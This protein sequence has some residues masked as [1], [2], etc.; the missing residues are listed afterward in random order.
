[1]AR[2]WTQMAKTLPNGPPN[3][4]ADV[5]NALNANP[6]VQFL[7]Q[8]IKAANNDGVFALLCLG[9]DYPS[10]I[11]GTPY[12]EPVTGKAATKRLPISYIDQNQPWDWWAMA[13][14]N[15]YRFQ[16][17]NGTLVGYVNSSQST[18]APFGNPAGAW[19]WGF[20][21][22]NE[23]NYTAWQND[24]YVAGVTNPGQANTHCTVVKMM[25]TLDA[26]I[27]RWGPAC[28]VLAPSLSDKDSTAYGDYNYMKYRDYYEYTGLLLDNLANWRPVA[29]WAWSHHNYLDI[30]NGTASTNG[31]PRRRRSQRLHH[32][33]RVSPHEL[34]RR[35]AVPSVD[36]DP[37][38]LVRP[39]EHR[40]GAVHVQSR[41]QH[42]RALPA[43]LGVAPAGEH[44]H[45]DAGRHAHGVDDLQ[46]HDMTPPDRAGGVAQPRFDI[47]NYQFPGEAG[48]LQRN[49]D[50][51]GLAAEIGANYGRYHE[52][53]AETLESL[54][55]LPAPDASGDDYDAYAQA[56]NAAFAVVFAEQALREARGTHLT[57]AGADPGE[58]R[59]C[60]VVDELHRLV[61]VEGKDA[62][63]LAR[64]GSARAARWRPPAN[65]L[66][67]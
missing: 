6:Y 38:R 17:V 48:K 10:W 42:V 11:N 61:A 27:A 3:S 8:M 24:P 57:S 53:L 34:Q 31:Q 13:L 4:P 30:E 44:Q 63:R 43:V 9:D 51:S 46:G 67:S 50:S 41:D 59:S 35:R 55:G 18:S 28:G 14:Y 54:G 39:Q 40:G 60:P 56:C 2:I 21:P 23:P 66:G 62:A 16:N 1:M 12:A 7:D 52:H 32:R 33:G 29:Y 15:R 26:A 19:I 25:M 37:A 49:G 64:R 20:E 58:W 5:Y 65:A 36:E 22:F 47:R 45:R